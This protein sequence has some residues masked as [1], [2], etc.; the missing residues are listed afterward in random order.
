[1]G[2]PEFAKDMTLRGDSDNHILASGDIALMLY[3][4]R[5]YDELKSGPLVKVA[6]PKKVRRRR[7]GTLEVA[8]HA[9]GRLAA[10]LIVGYTGL[11]GRPSLMHYFLYLLVRC[12][13]LVR[14]HRSPGQVQAS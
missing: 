10:S 3:E 6:R 8:R 14:S 12:Y 2:M 11:A 5:H 13:Q 7:S 1:M 9:P 4:R